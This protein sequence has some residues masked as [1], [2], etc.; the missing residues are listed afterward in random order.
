MLLQR[1]QKW[2][3]DEPIASRH[4]TVDTSPQQ[5]YKDISLLELSCLVL[6]TDSSE[7]ILNLLLL[8]DSPD[9]EIRRTLLK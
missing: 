7:T 3:L 5:S 9:P 1:G 6:E 8:P 2:P 4:D